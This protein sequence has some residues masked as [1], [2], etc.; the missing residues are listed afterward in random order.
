MVW[1]LYDSLKNFKNY[2]RETRKLETPIDVITVEL[3]DNLE[4]CINV[5]LKSN[6]HRVFLVDDFR[7][8]IKCI[9]IGDI[10]HNILYFGKE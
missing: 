2:V 1:R 8:P 3:N 10:L 4:T 9:S 5:L 7:R 6:T